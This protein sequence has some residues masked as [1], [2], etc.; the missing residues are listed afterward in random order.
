MFHLNWKVRKSNNL[1][2]RNLQICFD[3]YLIGIVLMFICDVT[4]GISNYI[5]KAAN[6]IKCC[7]FS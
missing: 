4:K 1:V 6:F 2:G 3:L 7:K 5:L